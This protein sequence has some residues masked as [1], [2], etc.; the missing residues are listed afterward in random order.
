MVKAY[1][2]AATKC[3]AGEVYN[4]CSEKAY[5]MKDVLDMLLS[6]SKSKQKIKIRKD[7][8]R[9]RPSDVELL[10]GDCS[11]FKEATGWKPSIPFSQTL[12]DTLDYW[13][14]KIKTSA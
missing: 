10:L 7:P 13:K 1:Y 12:Q 5:K 11:K 3:K 14:S 9:L 8:A 2:L 4:I 6:L